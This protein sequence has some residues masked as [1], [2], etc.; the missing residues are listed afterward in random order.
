MSDRPKIFEHL[1]WIGHDSFRIDQPVTIYIDPWNLPANSPE[2]ELI[3]V[4]H[5]HHDHCSPED[6]QSVRKDHTLV[7]AN[8]GAAEKLE[9]PVEIMHAGE[10]KIHAGIKIEAVPAYNLDKPF[11]PKEEKHLGFILEIDG[12]RL[13]FAGDTDHIPEMESIDCDLALLPVSGKYV[14]DAEEA[15]EAASTL[16]PKLIVPM[17]YGA[18][19]VG[20]IADAERF[21]ELTD[22]P[23]HIMDAETIP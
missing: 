7:I 17:H 1:H 11:H 10:T 22:I 3:L 18:G 12:E 5:D 9:A 19:V 2:A 13:Y 8:P 23:V 14:M 20:T 21:K 6:V 15:A 4:S 16:R